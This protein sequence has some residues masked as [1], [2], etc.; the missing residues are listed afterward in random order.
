MAALALPLLSTTAAAR[1]PVAARWAREVTTGAA[2]ILLAVNTA[3]AVTGRPS[4]VATS[5]EVGVAARLDAAVDAR[6]DEAPRR[7]DA[8]GYT[9][10]W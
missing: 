2:V 4:A 9:P 7:G 1:P 5:D 8:H 6:G 10:R 3:A